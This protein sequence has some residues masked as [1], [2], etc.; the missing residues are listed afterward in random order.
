[1]QW[2][3]HAGEILN[4]DYVAHETQ[5]LV[6]SASGDQTVRLWTLQGHY[7]GTFGQDQPWDLRNP[8]TFQHPK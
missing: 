3:A 8:S 7:V 1:M 4:I 6:L 5:P 2:R